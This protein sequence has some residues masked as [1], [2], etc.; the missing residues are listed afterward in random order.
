VWSPTEYAIHAG[1]VVEMMSWLVHAMTTKELAPFD[2]VEPSETTVDDPPPRMTYA[3]AVERLEAGAKRMDAELGRL[4]STDWARTVTVGANV[5]DVAGIARHAVH[6]SSH[7]LADV[8]RGLH[9]LGAGAP[10]SKGT[11]AGVFASG[12]GVPKQPI[13]E[14]FVGY[15]GVEGDRQAT[16]QHHGRVW[17]ALCLWS[18][19]V[20]E[21]FQREGHPIAPGNAGENVSIAG[22]DWPSLRPGT[23]IAIGGGVLAEVSAYATPCKNNAG[24]FLDGD[25]NRMNHDR[26]PGVSRVYASVLRD[27]VIR[28]NDLVIVEP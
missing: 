17:Q 10:R 1:D 5:R 26:E 4:D 14:A 15:R 2:A 23:R 19:D 20:V 27:G 9:T 7:H 25:F 22:I 8:A 13:D 21:R 12:G 18:A 11:V 24:W 3:E 6:D 16:R 28:P